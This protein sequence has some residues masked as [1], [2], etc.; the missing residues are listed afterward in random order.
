MKEFKAVIL[1][2]EVGG[3][4]RARFEDGR[5]EQ[6]VFD[7]TGQGREPGATGKAVYRTTSSSGLWY[8]IPDKKNE[9][10]EVSRV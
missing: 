6:V 3:Y 4:G 7:M 5:E 2:V 1:R 10:S 9:I 8:W